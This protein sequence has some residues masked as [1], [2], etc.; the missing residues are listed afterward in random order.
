MSALETE[1]E[2]MKLCQETLGQDSYDEWAGFWR[3]CIRGNAQYPPKPEKVRRVMAAVAVDKRE[4]KQFR[5]IGAYAYDL[6]TKRFND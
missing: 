6:F 5:D 2:L 4:G 3:V 1:A